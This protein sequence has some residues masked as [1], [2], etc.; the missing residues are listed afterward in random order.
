VRGAVRQPAGGAS[1]AQRKRAT[2]RAAIAHPVVAGILETI[3]SQLVGLRDQQAAIIVL[4]HAAARKET[5]ILSK[6]ILMSV[7]LD[8]LTA[9]VTANT[10]QIASA[11]T[12]INGIAGRIEA[13]GTDPVKLKALTAELRAKD[14]ELAAAVAA[15]TPAAP[16]A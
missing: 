2:V 9:Q 15:N 10:D 3:Q 1:K 11:I 8:D 16:P 5:A 7:E 13:A 6:E 12:L 4:L 14:D